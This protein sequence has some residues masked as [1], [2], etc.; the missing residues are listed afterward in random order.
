VDRLHRRREQ[1][2]QLRAEGEGGV[3]NRL[4]VQLHADSRAGYR[5]G[6]PGAG[7]GTEVL[8]TD[9]AAYGGS[10]VGNAGGV[11]AE[12]VPMHQPENIPHC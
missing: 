11:F 10:N 4:R 9:A 1:R 6:L 8:D 12:F 5:V 2:H 7:S 3:R